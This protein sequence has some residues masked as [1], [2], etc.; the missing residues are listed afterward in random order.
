MEPMMQNSR[1]DGFSGLGGTKRDYFQG[2]RRRER[3]PASQFFKILLA[4]AALVLLPKVVLGFSMDL[5][6]DCSEAQ[7]CVV[8]NYF[9][10]DPSINYADYVCGALSYNG[11]QGTDIRVSYADMRRG[12][13]VLAAAEGTVRAV[14]DSEPEG[15]ISLRDLASIKGREAGNGVV[16]V[17]AEGY[18]TQY[19]HLLKGSVAVYPGQRVRAGQRLGMVG[20][21]GATEFPHLEISVRQQ[22]QAVDPFTGNGA[23]GCGG[24]AQ[25][26][27][28]SPALNSP[29][30]QYRASGLLEAGFFSKP[31]NNSIALLRRHGWIEGQATDLPVLV[32]GVQVFGPKEG[33]VWTLR[34]TGPDSRILGESRT[35]Q[36]RNQA[37][38]MRYIGKK[39]E[40][41]W[42]P[43]LYRGEFS[44]T[45]TGG[46]V[47]SAVREIE[48][49]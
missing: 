45:R 15:E 17:H 11:H 14:R 34:L 13:P 46:Q 49:R 48:I 37:Q 23:A 28:S 2:T 27:W 31:P 20:L 19:S 47:L 35:T 6:V 33:D 41:A 42:M 32:F 40:A 8:Q 12:I 9:D 5:P 4:V 30:L 39:K 25:P 36:Q 43:G 26:L 18:E 22:G 3:H 21:S 16:L 44:L 1:R 24:T 29:V 7:T 10:H 38:A